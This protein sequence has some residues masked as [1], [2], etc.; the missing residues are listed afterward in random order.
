MISLLWVRVA[1]YATIVVV[2]IAFGAGIEHRRMQA[3]LDAVVAV[4]SQFVGGTEALGRKAQAEAAAARLAGIKA[5]ERADEDHDNRVAVLG[6]TIAGLRAD[7]AARD[8]RGGSVSASPAGSVCAEGLV[9]FDR[10]EYQ[11]ALGDFDSAARRLADEGT[12]VAVDLD[13]VINWAKG[14]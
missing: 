4:H 11:R 1:I 14:E 7:A 10:A 3:K 2:L 6:R 12:K 5:K 8:S 13:T 9:C